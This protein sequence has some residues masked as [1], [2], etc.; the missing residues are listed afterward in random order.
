VKGEAYEFDDLLADDIFDDTC[1]FDGWFCGFAG[2]V[3]HL[4]DLLAIFVRLA[5]S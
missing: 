3:H 5:I 4:T 1:C 2:D